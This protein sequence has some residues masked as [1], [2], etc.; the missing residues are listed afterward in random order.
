[1][2]H[3]EALVCVEAHEQLPA[4]AL[5]I[6]I[7]S[8]PIMPAFPLQLWLRLLQRIDKLQPTVIAV[9]IGLLSVHTAIWQQAK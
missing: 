2:K 3:R 1:M 9:I 8:V 5:P 6:P 7:V 4:S